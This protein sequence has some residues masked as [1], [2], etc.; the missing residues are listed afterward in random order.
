VKRARLF[1]LVIATTAF[2]TAAA[3]GGNDLPPSSTPLGAT[4]S[5]PV[6]AEKVER[7]VTYCERD[8]VALQMDVYQPETGE[9][10]RPAVLFLHAGAW[11]MGDKLNT[12]GIVD[13]GELLQRGYVV[14]SIDYGLP[15]DFTFP[16]QLQN[17]Q[18]AVRYLRAEAGKHNIDP[19]R[20][21]VWGASA[22]G[23]LAALLGVV[24]EGAGF[25]PAGGHEEQSSR[26]QAVV[27]LFGPA[28][29]QQPAFVPNT[30]EIARAVFGAEGAGPSPALE[31]ASPVTYVSVDDPRS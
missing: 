15:P 14:A 5:P 7:G 12:G 11:V 27:D 8:G 13:F 31:R 9:G 16:A 26:V 21:A 3:C 2:A 28:D 6:P 23:H 18:C 19:Q 10:A 30:D 29:L 25:A 1:G 4:P 22:G 17:A 20:I 24:D